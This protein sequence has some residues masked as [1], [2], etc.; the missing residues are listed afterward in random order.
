MTDTENAPDFGQIYDYINGATD[1]ADRQRRRANL[2]YLL[3]TGGIKSLK[4]ILN[5]F[6]EKPHVI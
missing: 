1:P 3:Y 5:E 2:E 6:K 4:E